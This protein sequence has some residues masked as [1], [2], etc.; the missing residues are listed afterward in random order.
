MKTFSE[1]LIEN[2][3]NESLLILES[4]EV[5]NALKKLTS[6]KKSI[7]DLD[8]FKTLIKEFDEFVRFTPPVGGSFAYTKMRNE[9]SHTIASVKNVIDSILKISE[10]DEVKKL[11]ETVKSISLTVSITYGKNAQRL[12]R[13]EG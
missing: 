2:Q 12:K 7:E 1:L 11:K 4:A 10:I 9:L 3:I 5:R 13:A 6:I 8:I